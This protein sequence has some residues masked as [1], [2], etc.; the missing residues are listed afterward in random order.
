MCYQGSQ[1]LVG[2]FGK[3]EQLELF[4]REV[5]VAGLANHYRVAND[6]PDLS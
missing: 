5:N 2:E 3:E 6:V 4:S 1:Q